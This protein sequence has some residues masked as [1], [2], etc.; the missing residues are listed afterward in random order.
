MSS[1]VRELYR[2]HGTSQFVCTTCDSHTSYALRELY[3][4][5]QQVY[6]NAV[7]TIVF[8]MGSGTSL[9]VAGIVQLVYEAPWDLS[10]CVHS[11]WQP[12]FVRHQGAVEILSVCVRKCRL[13]HSVR[14][15]VVICHAHCRNRAPSVRGSTGTPSS[16]TQPVAAV[17]HPL[18][19]SCTDQYRSVLKCRLCQRVRHGVG[20]CHAGI[21]H[22]VYKA[23][24]DSQFAY[25]AYG[26]R[27]ASAV[28]ELYR[29]I[30]QVY[31]DAVYAK[32]FSMGWGAAIR[33]ARNRIPRA[34]DSKGPPS[35]CTQT[36]AA[37]W[38]PW[39]WSCTDPYS[40]CTKMPLTPGCLPSG[41]E[42]P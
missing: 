1:T 25:V 13:Q 24:R 23:P 17:W 29:P 11:Q 15:G 14:H 5:V 28:R 30:Q 22:L 19:W 35:L 38:H 34:R 20:N 18:S 41:G 6:E 8:A 2:V 27:T 16:C 4:S 42:L 31:K 39:P 9:C 26:S 12:Y 33:V 7:G 37:I 21:A 10:V 32:V 36:V 3:G 40:G